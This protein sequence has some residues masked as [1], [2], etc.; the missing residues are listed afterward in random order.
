MEAVHYNVCSW[1]AGNK[2]VVSTSTPCPNYTVLEGSHPDDWIGLGANDDQ[3]D[4][5]YVVDGNVSYKTLNVFGR[6]HLILK[7]GATLTCSGGIIVEL[8]HNNAKLF[9]YSQGNRSVLF[10]GGGSMLYYPKQD[11]TVNAFRVFFQLH[12]G[13]KAGEM[14]VA[15]A[16]AFVLDFGDGSVETGILSVPLASGSEERSAANGWYDLQGRKYSEKPTAKGLYIHGGK[17]VVVK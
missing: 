14:D 10:M 4:H 12:N 2:K 9:I 7:D 1:D 13:L 3:E 5:Y 15:G 17:K 11:V 8:R 16:K 6:A